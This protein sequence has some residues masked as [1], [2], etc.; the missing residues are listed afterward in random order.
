MNMA[1]L[2]TIPLE[3]IA[4]LCGDLGPKDLCAFRQ[5][6]K[7]IQEATS[8]HVSRYFRT[9]TAM[10]ERSSL[11]G[12]IR[13]SMH[14]GLGHA[15]QVVQL[16]IDHL[17]LPSEC[18]DVGS[19][20]AYHDLYQ[21][22]MDFWSSGQDVWALELALRT[23]PNCR[24][25][26]ITNKHRPWGAMRL[27]DGGAV[28]VRHLDNEGGPL[29]AQ[30]AV[31]HILA[32]AVTAVFRSKAV[33]TDIDIDIGQPD[34]PANFNRLRRRFIYESVEPW[35]FD[36][37]KYN[38]L[39]ELCLSSVTTIRLIVAPEDTSGPPGYPRP[40]ERRGHPPYDVE[41]GFLNFLHMFPEL[42]DLSL[43]C[44]SRM[45][46]GH[47]TARLL[48]HLRVE[49]LRRLHIESFTTN[50]GTI[51]KF[52]EAHKTTLEDV[53]LRSIDLYGHWG[54]GFTALLISIS[55]MPRMQSIAIQECIGA[56]VAHWPEILF[57]EEDV[58]SKIRQ[59]L[60]MTES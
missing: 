50:T 26:T 45:R 22:Q 14:P 57:H 48:D 9:C 51:E 5:T 47:L 13:L 29:S 59:L 1:S 38:Q 41:R 30:T 39:P 32:A 23:L 52:L 25:L 46:S 21:A 2:F 54:E 42:S 3:I 8:K 27:E 24:M 7:R 37:Q 6:C 18:G 58:S 12:L 11:E 15:V 44:G 56:H 33:I 10:L 49:K 60:G 34:L 17:A 36:L 31:G 53:T 28:L 35:V 16:S 40:G 43:I 20:K 19:S 4:Q 55:D